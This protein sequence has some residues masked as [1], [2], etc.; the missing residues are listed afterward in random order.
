MTNFSLLGGS[1]SPQ[2]CLL[3]TVRTKV[4]ATKS[5]SV[6]GCWP[7][8]V[9]YKIEKPNTFMGL[10]PPLS[11]VDMLHATGGDFHTWWFPYLPV[12]SMVWA[13]C[14]PELLVLAIGFFFSPFLGCF[15]FMM[16]LAGF[17]QNTS[18]A[19]FINTRSIYTSD[20][21]FQFSD[22]GSLASPSRGI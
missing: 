21:L 17:H 9:H 11:L 1:L 19:G 20:I 6:F 16:F 13:V 7:L 10:L 8:L 2:V 15:L 5:K 22:V 4:L 14:L 12:A 18:L 3:A